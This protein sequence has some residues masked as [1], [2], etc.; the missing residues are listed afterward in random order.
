MVGPQD[1]DKNSQ[2]V[3][4]SFTSEDGEVSVV[5][6]STWGLWWP[7]VGPQADVWFGN[8]WPAPYDFFDGEGIGFVD[9]V[10]YDKWCAENGGNPLLSEPAN[11]AAIAQQLMNDADFETTAPVAAHIGG[12]DAISIDITLAPGGEACGVWGI[13]ISRWVHELRVGPGFASPSVPRRPPR[14]RAR[15]GTLAITV[16]APEASF[17]AFIEGTQPIIDSIE[18]HPSS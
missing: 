6:P 17:D 8:L 1:D 14:R 15:V 12:L 13:D 5:A 16:A 11:A 18:F 7:G 3:T 10:A 9:P 2:P 4:M